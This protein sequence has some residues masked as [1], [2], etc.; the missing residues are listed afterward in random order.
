MSRD[1]AMCHLTV[2][3]DSID[4]IVPLEPLFVIPDYLGETAREPVRPEATFVGEEQRRGPRRRKDRR[5]STS[6][7]IA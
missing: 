4:A 1:Q 6:L 3:D 5:T 7:R 2:G